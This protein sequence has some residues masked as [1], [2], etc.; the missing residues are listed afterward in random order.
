MAKAGRN[1]HDEFDIK[2]NKERTRTS[3]KMK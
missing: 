2:K 1:N 3:C